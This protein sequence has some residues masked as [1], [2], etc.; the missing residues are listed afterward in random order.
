MEVKFEIKQEPVIST[1]TEPNVVR[2]DLVARGNYSE[3]EWYK[4]QLNKIGK[5]K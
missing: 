1:S 5:K 2:L 4:K 3:I